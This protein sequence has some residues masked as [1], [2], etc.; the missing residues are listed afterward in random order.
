VVTRRHAGLLT[1][2]RV[3][4]HF[5]NVGSATFLRLAASRAQLLVMSPL[6]TLGGVGRNLPQ[7]QS[8][9]DC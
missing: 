7:L 5:I 6:A 1:G 8:V 9:Q 3:P 2:E 4:L